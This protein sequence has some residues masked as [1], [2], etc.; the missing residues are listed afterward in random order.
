MVWKILTKLNILELC[1]RNI[2]L[3]RELYWIATNILTG[4]KNAEGLIAHNA[5]KIEILDKTKNIT[6]SFD[7][8]LFYSI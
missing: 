8:I 3:V 5:L 7:S 6:S 4:N 2:I 1:T